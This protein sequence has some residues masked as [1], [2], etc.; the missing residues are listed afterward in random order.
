MILLVL[1]IA[2]L[3]YFLYIKYCLGLKDIPGPLLAAFSNCDRIITA[4]SGKQFL[5][6]IG[7]HEK[8]G[9]LVRVGPNHVSFSDAD[10]IPVVY[11]ITSKFYKVC[12]VKG[13]TRG[14]SLTSYQ[15]DFYS[16]FDAKSPQGPIPTVFSIRN[17]KQHKALKRPVANAYSMSALVELEPMTDECI[18]ILQRKLED[19]QGQQIDLGEWLQ[20][21]SFDVITTITFS[22]RLG[23]MEQEKDVSG[24]INAIEGRLAYN[25]VIG[26]APLLNKFLLGNRLVESLANYV[27]ALARLNS[28]RSIVEFAAKQL[29]RYKSADKSTERLR[30]MLARFKRSRDGEEVMSDKD[31]LSHASSNMSVSLVLCASFGLAIGDADS[32]SFAGSDTTAISLRSL[33]YYLCKNAAC[34]SRLMTEIDDLDRAGKLSEPVSFAEA[35]KMKYLQACMKEAMRMHPAVGQLLERVVP[36]GGAAL[37]GHWLPQ[38]TIVGVNPWVPSR[39]RSTY[40]KDADVYRPER[41]L[42]ADAAHLKLMERNFLAVSAQLRFVYSWFRYCKVGKDCD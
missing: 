30:D 31:L 16:L 35:N 39:D 4:A 11:G 13:N 40:G 15:S 28:A 18:A 7:Y 1:S 14:A 26:E 41:W 37:S 19:K 25:A 36:E 9:A 12:E 17:E 38:G 8:Y 6:H 2:V 22:N 42:E 34:Y 10:L 29:D 32:S 3:V 23:F 24:I 20:W 5:A 27:P 21:F 33:F